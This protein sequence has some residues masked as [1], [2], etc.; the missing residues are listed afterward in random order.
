MYGEFI[1]TA[2]HMD[3]IN[4]TQHTGILSLNQNF[5][6]FHFRLK[7]NGRHFKQN[8][9]HFEQNSRH[10]ADIFR[11]IFLDEISGFW[12]KISL[13]CVPGDLIDST[14]KSAMK[15][16][17]AWCCRAA[18]QYLTQY[19]TTKS[20]NLSDCRLVLLLPLANPLKPGVKLRM[21]M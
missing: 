21:K 20:Q 11:C 3:T 2:L 8:G 15:Q 18:H 19:W 4:I 1:F 17:M 13:M 16:I 12:L 10:F 5:I 6:S 14:G 7:Q 9:R